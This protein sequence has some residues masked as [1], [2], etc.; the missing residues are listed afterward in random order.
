M[1]AVG[2]FGGMSVIVKG[3]DC[4]KQDGIYKCTLFAHMPV[5][6]KPGKLVLQQTRLELDVDGK[7]R[8]K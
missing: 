5:K 6:G 8:C 7:L 3:D 2:G 1:I 4:D